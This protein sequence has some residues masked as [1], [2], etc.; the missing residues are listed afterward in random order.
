M[1]KGIHPVTFVCTTLIWIIAAREQYTK[2]RQAEAQLAAC[3]Q[4]R[5]Y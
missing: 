3:R 2:R 1:S 4:S 5:D